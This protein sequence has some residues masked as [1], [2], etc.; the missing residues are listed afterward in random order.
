MKSRKS[1]LNKGKAKYDGYTSITKSEDLMAN[2]M[3]SGVVRGM[4]VIVT[5]QLS[6]PLN[7]GSA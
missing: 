1:T 4:R 3:I 7:D 6:T 2:K 5:Y